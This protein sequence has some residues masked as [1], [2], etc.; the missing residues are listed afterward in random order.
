VGIQDSDIEEKL[1]LIFMSLISKNI[2]DI[3]N[4]FII[5]RKKMITRKHDVRDERK[6]IDQM[7]LHCK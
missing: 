4:I 1:F 6:S 5:F 3:P 7:P 2:L